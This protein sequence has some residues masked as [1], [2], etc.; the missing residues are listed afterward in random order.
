LQKVDDLEIELAEKM[1]DWLV[2]TTVAN[3]VSMMVEWKVGN[4]VELMD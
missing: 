4:S 1:V 3:L 2:A